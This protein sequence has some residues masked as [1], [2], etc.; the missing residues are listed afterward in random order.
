[1]MNKIVISLSILVVIYGIYNSKF[2]NQKIDVVDKKISKYR[3]HTLKHQRDHLEDELSNIDSVAYLKEYIISVINHGSYDLGFVGGTMEGGFASKEDAPK[4][5][6]FVV[7]LS[8]KKCN[9]TYSKDAQM[10]Y[11][12]IC[13]GC[14][15]NDG[16]G[17]G[18]N[19]PDLTN[20]KLI[21]IKKREEF[22][23]NLHNHIE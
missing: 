14:H 3:E 15:G 7:E 1:M 10:F 23:T 8:G 5:A 4:I 19:Y 9:E 21:G 2:S 16:K 13:G 6:C 20:K 11:T 17:L 12:S 22:L 18:G